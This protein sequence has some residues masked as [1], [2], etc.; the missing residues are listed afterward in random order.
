MQ[1]GGLCL[2]EDTAVG[3]RPVTA[4]TVAIRVP[5]GPV[6]E[7]CIHGQWLAGTGPGCHCLHEETGAPQVSTAEVTCY[8]AR[9]C[10]SMLLLILKILSSSM[11]DASSTSLR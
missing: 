2:F 5:E 10:C 8:G 1:A 11:R 9:C 4:P 6:A 3:Q 7:A